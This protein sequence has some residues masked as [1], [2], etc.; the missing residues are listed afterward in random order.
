MIQSGQSPNKRQDSGDYPLLHSMQGGDTPTL[1]IG[2][3]A[4]SQ[5]LYMWRVPFG[6]LP[7]NKGSPG[8][9]LPGIHP[10]MG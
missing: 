10:S 4:Y 6:I 2:Y 7:G 5:P 3:Y 8:L 1:T 9:L